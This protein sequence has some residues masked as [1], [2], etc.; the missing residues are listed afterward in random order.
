MN[1]KFLC[2]LLTCTATAGSAW[3]QQYPAKPIQAIVPFAAGSSNDI[4]A[5]LVT[6]PMTRS[7]GQTVV[8][9]NMPGADGRIGIAALAKAAPDGYTILFSGG[10]ISL[11]PALRKNVPYNPDKDIQPVA[12]LASGPYVIVVNPKVPAK[13]LKEFV[14]YARKNPG[15]LNGSS[16]G[17]STFMSLVLLQT[18][19]GTKIQNIP[20]K[21]TG[22]AAAAIVQGEAD[23]AAMD[24][25][26]FASFIPSGKVRALAVAGPKR[27][28]SLPDVPTTREAGLPEFVAGTGFGVYTKLG[29]PMP[30]VNR[31]NA[32]VNKALA[33]PEV[34]AYLKKIGLEPGEGSADEFMQQYKDDLARWKTVVAKAGLPLE[35]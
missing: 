31:L 22:L 21:G 20:Y 33:A 23:V 12:E 28:P 16:G 13:S 34:A 5:R 15:K 25:S 4:M 30:I 19:I 32:E 26:A 8:V 14:E 1:I 24:G 3:A 2:T 9:Q 17:N 27:L 35:D 29:T 10:A 18:V 11:I 6:P 7:M